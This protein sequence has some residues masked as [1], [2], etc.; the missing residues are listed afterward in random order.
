MWSSHTG[1]DNS[2]RDLALG[3]I[4]NDKGLG[5]FVC[6]YYGDVYALNGKDGTVLWSFST[7]GWQIGLALGDSLHAT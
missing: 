5:I 3:K 2:V 7:G 1:G 6:S 4:N